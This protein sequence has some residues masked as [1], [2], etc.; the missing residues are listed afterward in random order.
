MR[1]RGVGQPGTSPVSARI[2][3]DLGSAMIEFIVLAVF[4][5]IPLV[6]VLLTVFQLQAASYGLSQATREAGRAYVTAGEDEDP[7]ARAVTAASI[8]MADQG[9]FPLSA[10][11]LVV[12]DCSASP[13]L[14]PGGHIT[15]SITYA[16]PL[17]LLPSEVFG[18]RPATVSIT[19]R[20][21][22]YVDRFRVRS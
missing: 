22:E 18:A 17:P 16:V 21:V 11:Q 10:S 6:Y 14:T 4:L 3:D 12:G 7:T 15:F 8:A 9:D 13:C 19:S 5:M 2:R 20:H 1:Q